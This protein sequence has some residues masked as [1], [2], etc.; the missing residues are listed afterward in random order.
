MQQVKSTNQAQNMLLPTYI[1]TILTIS[2]Y[3]DDEC[4]NSILSRGSMYSAAI[5][6]NDYETEFSRVMH[7]NRVGNFRSEK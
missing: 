2:P 3:I 6:V 1:Q 5:F 4:I 7:V